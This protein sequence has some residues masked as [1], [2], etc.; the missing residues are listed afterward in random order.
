M[1]IEKQNMP[2]VAMEFMNDVHGEDIDIINELFGLILD[3]E[4]NPTNELKE[5]VA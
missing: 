1:L 2:M 3:Y 5:S 4:K